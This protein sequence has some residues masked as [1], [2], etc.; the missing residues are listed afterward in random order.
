MARSGPLS[1]TTVRSFVLGLSV[2]GCGTSA[3]EYTLGLR[4]GECGSIHDATLRDDCLVEHDRCDEVA[5]TEAAAECWF[6]RAEAHGDADACAHAGAFEFDC[7][8]HLFT[9]GFDTWVESGA[10]PGEGEDSVAAHAVAAGLAA[11][12]PRV[13]SAWYRRV[14]TPQAPLD[15]GSCDAAPDPTRR[16]ACRQTALAVW[17]DRLNVA[18]DRHLWPCD[19]SPRPPLLQTT[20][21]PELDAQT[22]A[23]T[24]LCPR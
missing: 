19:G 22:A 16:E 14:L 20:P 9:R 8:M 18:R 24:D 11:D 7:R 15:R 5:G 12:D 1:Q 3:S 4:S 21:D 23:R 17:Q 2:A 6:R 10:R 13:W